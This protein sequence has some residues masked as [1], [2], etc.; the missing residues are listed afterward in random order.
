M[1]DQSQPAASARN[2]AFFISPHGFGHAARATSIMEALSAIDP[3][4]CFDIFTTVPNWFFRQCHTFTFKYH[5]M[6]TDIGLVQQ[7]PFQADLAA[8][9]RA[10][11]QFIPFDPAQIVSRAERLRQQNCE[12][13]V[14]DIAPLGIR[15]A[16]KAG[17]P[18]VLIENF[19]WPWLYRGY[20]DKRLN[21]FNPYLQAVFVDAN[22]HIQTQ[23]ICQSTD[24]DF[25][26]APASRKINRPARVIRRSLGLSDSFKVV[27]VTA[28]GAPK[29]FSFIGKL[30]RVKDIHFILPGTADSE[31]RQDNLLLLPEN[32]AYFH[33]DLINAADAVVG[34]V[35]YSTIA[36]VYQAGIPFGYVARSGNREM[37]PLV[38]FIENQMSGLAIAESDFHD[39][40]FTEHL[41]NLL[42][43]SGTAGNRPNGADQIAGFIADLLK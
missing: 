8:T 25:L 31:S 14:C 5:R 38:N 20:N 33:P 26:A 24:A 41:D 6:L 35:G 37:Q 3:T 28:G 18:S 9:V 43:I 2:I 12:L 10:L 27:M 39:G 42:K 22:Y 16:Q 15:I 19:T 17:V 23:P 36:E 11:K 13:V 7:T 34:K 4:F 40:T 1:T 21:E 32:S 30:K 29:N